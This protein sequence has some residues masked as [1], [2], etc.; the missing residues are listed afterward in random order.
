MVFGNLT[1]PLTG[2]L[3]Y[4]DHTSSS[5]RS[6]RHCTLSTAGILK[7]LLLMTCFQILKIKFEDDDTEQMYQSGEARLWGNTKQS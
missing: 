6:C 4:S 7:G 2:L 3:S 5:H 1:P